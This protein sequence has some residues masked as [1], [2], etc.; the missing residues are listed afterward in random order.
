[1]YGDLILLHSH[2]IAVYNRVTVK[3]CGPLVFIVFVNVETF[4]LI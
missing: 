2:G 3:A 4:I 1:M